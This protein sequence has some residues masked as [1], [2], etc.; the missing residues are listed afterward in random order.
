[1]ELK[2]NFSEER[3]RLYRWMRTQLFGFGSDND[4]D[5]TAT[6]LTGMKPSER[7]QC[8]VLFP[9]MAKATESVVEVDL[10]EDVSGMSADGAEP[11]QVSYVRYVPPSSVGFSFYIVGENAQLEVRAWGVRYKINDTNVKDEHRVWTRYPLSRAEETLIPFSPS[12]IA[13][14]PDFRSVEIFETSHD[15][16]DGKSKG[17]IQTLWRRYGL[18]WI[19]TVSLCNNQV[20]ASINEFPDA[21]AWQRKKEESTLFEVELECRILSGVVGDYPRT[22]PSLLNDEDQD[23]ELQYQH[24][25]IYAIGHGAAVDWGDPA[26]GPI[27]K[28]RA[29]FLPTVEVPQV[30]ADTGNESENALDLAFLAEITNNPTAVIQSLSDFVDGYAD[31]LTE[32]EQT[33]TQLTAHQ[34][35]ANR[36][37]ARVSQTL[38]RM[39]NG[40][41]RLQDDKVAQLA[42]SIANR[43]MLLQMKQSQQVNGQTPRAPRWRPFQLGFVLTSLV[44]SIDEDSGD[45]DLVDLIWFPTGGGKTE[46]YLALCAFV[47]AWRRRKF[48]ATGGGTTV[49]M[50][51][52]LRLLTAQQFERANRL[53][54]AL[55]HLRKAEPALGLGSTQIDIGIWVGG[56]TSPNTFHNA[57]DTVVESTARKTV[58]KKLLVTQ[59]PWC[60]TA[61]QA[62]TNYRAT[63][64]SF[65]F[66]C[67]NADCSFSTHNGCEALPCNVVDEAL[68]ENPPTLLIGTIDKFA[69]LA[70]DPRTSVFFGRSGNRP[71]DLIIQDELHLIAGPLGS[72]AG[73]YEAAIDTVIQSKGV[74]PKYVASSAT[75]RNAAEQVRQLYARETAIFPPPG[76]SADDAY[77]AKTVPIEQRPGRMYVGYLAPARA[78]AESITPLAAA[79]LAAP[80]ILFDDQ[81]E[82]ELLLDAWWTLVS[83]HGSL[84]GIGNAYN[85]IDKDARRYIE[86]YIQAAKAQSPQS[87]NDERCPDRLDSTRRRVQQ[88]SSVVDGDTN[89]TT[90][91]R[92]AKT[93]QDDDR[94]DVLVSTNM[95]SVGVDIPR[96]AA[97]I[98]NGQPLTTAEY[99][100]ASSRVGRGDVPG[101]VFTNYYRNQVRSW[102]HFESFRAYHESFYRHVEPT[103]VTPFS[104]PCRKRALHAA[105]VI[106]MRHG[107]GLLSE[108]AV[109]DFDPAVPH[110]SN[111]ITMLENRCRNAD[112]DRGDAT[113]AHLETLQH[114]WRAFIEVNANIMPIKYSESDKQKNSERLL[115]DFDA[116][117]K[118][119]WPT[120]QSMRNVEH[121]AL[122]K[123]T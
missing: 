86:A 79:L 70:W 110:I 52:T 21:K 23:L 55:E 12:N 48:L 97:M 39:R 114:E 112:S 82:R 80:T 44:S 98:V 87:G 13:L 107:A 118:G 66:Q 64:T 116:R 40:I 3:M 24:R 35:A 81:S 68:F 20:C 60:G 108:A 4:N 77:F 34:P 59:C 75:I 106:V 76:L 50:R 119:V 37:L 11:S 1:M 74:R 26:K 18:G 57:V 122:V 27:A 123:L 101:I 96:L 90:F 61:F 111:L 78:P 92:L 102:S 7:F 91:A 73:V 69:R 51:Y 105:L 83:Y 29:D 9:V 17:V 28:I 120:L 36:I 47:I 8:G 121:V 115:Y 88:L 67:H 65:H 85:A 33:A 100:Q 43:A 45:R 99:I 103:S 93:W 63:A 22:D 46:A 15:H 5:D 30:T 10:S 109:Q 2:M 6:N 19:V 62:P 32:R 117:I 58:P 25:R 41:K 71:P 31:W 113:A 16:P 104:Y 84:K 54:F 42:F 94:L 95:I 38:S 56:N 14:Q 89:H 53:I 72:V 49:L